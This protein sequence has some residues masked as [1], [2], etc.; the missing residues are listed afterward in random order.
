MK[1]Y[2]KENNALEAFKDITKNISIELKIKYN[3]ALKVASKLQAEVKIKNPNISNDKL[4]SVC[5]KYLSR[6]IDKFKK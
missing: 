3:K 4:T 1:I 2:K 5:K 6:N